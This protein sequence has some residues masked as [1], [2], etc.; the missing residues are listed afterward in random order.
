MAVVVCSARYA[1]DGN[2][3]QELPFTAG[4]VNG[5]KVPIVLKKGV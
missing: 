4:V 2:L 3:D 5:R 1:G